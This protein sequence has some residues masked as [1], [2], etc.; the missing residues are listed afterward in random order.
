MNSH[1]PPLKFV[2][3]PLQQGYVFIFD[4]T[5]FQGRTSASTASSIRAGSR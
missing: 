1:I 3:S 2:G 5:T 4:I